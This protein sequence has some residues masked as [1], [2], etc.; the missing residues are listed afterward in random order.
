MN[1]DTIIIIFFLTGNM[2]VAQISLNIVVMIKLFFS[3]KSPRVISTP[4][5]LVCLNFL[6]QLVSIDVSI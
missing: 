1:N 4:C 3:G 5:E 6:S 2:I